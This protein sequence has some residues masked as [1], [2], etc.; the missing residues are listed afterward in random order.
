MCLECS[1]QVVVVCEYLVV[2]SYMLR[3]C[4]YVSQVAVFSHIYMCLLLA[5]AFDPV[6]EGQN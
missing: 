3:V 2:F 4:F 1:V 6:L 5:L